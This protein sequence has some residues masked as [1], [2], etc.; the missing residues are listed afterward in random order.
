MNVTQK[1]FT[2]V[3]SLRRIWPLLWQSTPQWTILSTSLMLA[4]VVAGLAS[5]YLVKRLV[6]VLTSALGAEQGTANLTRVVIY[7]VLTAAATLVHLVAKAVA[8]FANETQGQIVSEYVDTIIH[9]KAIEADLSF[10][11][12]PL[13]FDTLQ[14]ARQGGSTRPAGVVSNLLQL[15]RNLVMLLAIGGLM[16]SIHWL[17]LPVLLL[18]VI[19]GLLVRLHFTRI[20]YDWERRRTQMQRRVGY[21]DYLITSDWHAK[22][23]RLN[24][25]GPHLREVYRILQLQLRRER[26]KISRQRTLVELIIASA[27][28]VAFFLSL[29]YLAWR[30]SLGQT[31]LGDLVLFLLV[32]QRGQGAVQA[33]LGNISRT[34]ADHLYLSQLF[35]FLD[36]RP[37]LLEPASPRPIPCPMAQGVVMENVTFQ[38]PGAPGV[39]LRNISL[40]VR[41]GEIVALVGANGS[42]KTTLIKVLCRLYDPTEG[43]L[44]LDGVDA[45]E[46]GLEDFNRVFSVIFQDYTHYAMTVRD[47]IRFGDIAQPQDSPDIV[48]AA[49]AAGADEFIQQLPRGYDT[50]L[51]RTFDDGQEISIGQWQKLALARAFL[52]QSQV[53]VLDEPTSALDANA[54]FNLFRDF[55]DRIGHRSAVIISHRLSTVRMADY[56]YVLDKGQIIEHGNHDTLISQDGAYKQMFERQAYYYQ[57]SIEQEGTANL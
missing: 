47:N 17:L 42:G 36:I 31:S 8:D 6:D 19:P 35:E 51:S 55:R 54:E 21:V 24:Q 44:T 26:L 53:I 2:I 16:V 27:G 13:Y 57:H 25:L 30:T 41:P 38:Y 52:H 9:A 45:C 46:Y 5:L 48:K 34:Y 22:E 39:A 49:I 7:V 40:K 32:F 11:E 29:A 1:L 33:L 43:R 18:G 28:T 23:L 12:S 14:R 37:T 15:G 50:Q 3:S 20:L 56:I 4:E 10:Y